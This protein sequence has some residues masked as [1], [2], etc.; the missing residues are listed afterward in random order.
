M[1]YQGMCNSDSELI[2]AF[3]HRMN[4]DKLSLGDY[5]L[6]YDGTMF[7]FTGNEISSMVKKVEAPDPNIQKLVNVLNYNLHPKKPQITYSS[8]LVESKNIEDI[9]NIISEIKKLDILIESTW[10]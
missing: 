8:I 6:L 10:K 5:Y 2:T 3:L 7:I 4:E 1:Q 9:L